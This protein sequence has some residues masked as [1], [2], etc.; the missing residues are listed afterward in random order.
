MNEEA[1]KK[2]VEHLKRSRRDMFELREYLKVDDKDTM[3]VESAL[4]EIEK[5]LAEYEESTEK[6]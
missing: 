5:L 4:T 2:F 6:D 1:R 3:F